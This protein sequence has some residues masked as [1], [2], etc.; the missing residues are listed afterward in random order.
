MAIRNSLTLAIAKLK[1]YAKLLKECPVYWSAQ[2]LHPSFRDKWIQHNLGEK[3]AKEVLASCHKLYEDE[4]FEE[5]TPQPTG[6]S[7]GS[8]VSDFI[9]APWLQ[10]AQPVELE[11]IRNE[12]EEYLKEWPVAC[13]DPIAFWAGSEQRFPRLARMAYDVLS[14]PTSSAECERIFSLAKLIVSS[15]RHKLSAEM[16]NVLQCLKCW[17]RAGFC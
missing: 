3:E 7:A 15:Q 8:V 14:A 9:N 6:L 12:L 13:H 11:A 10:Q 1:K 4:Y 17:Q 5:A 16:I 2:I